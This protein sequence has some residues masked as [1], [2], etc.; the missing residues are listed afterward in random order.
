MLIFIFFLCTAEYAREVISSISAQ[1]DVSRYNLKTFGVDQRADLQKKFDAYAW[2]KLT[3]LWIPIVS[4][5]SLGLME[6]AFKRLAND[7]AHR[8][9]LRKSSPKIQ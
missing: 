1:R 9:Q 5:I 6:A 3:D 8:I 2:P 7:W 4:T